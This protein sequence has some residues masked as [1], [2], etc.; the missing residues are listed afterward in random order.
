MEADLFYF[1]VLLLPDT[2]INFVL[3]PSNA[4]Q[5][6][7]VLDFLHGSKSAVMSVKKRLSLSDARF[8]KLICSG[9]RCTVKRSCSPPF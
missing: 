9:S 8:D 5:E 2:G 4:K 1:S 7:R 3:L 6:Q